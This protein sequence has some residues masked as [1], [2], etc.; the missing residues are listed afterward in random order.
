[1]EIQVPNHDITEIV[2]VRHGQTESNVTG[3]FMGWSSED[4]NAAGEEQAREL[5]SRL[6]AWSL[7]AAF[8][9]PLK[10]TTHTAQIIAGPYSIEVI[11]LEDLIEINQ[12]ELQ[13][14]RRSE[15]EKKWP[16]LCQHLRTD[17]SQ[18]VFPGGESFSQVAMRTVA[19]FTSVIAQNPG[20]RTLLVSH[21]INI[22]IIVM[23]VL[24]VPY[25]VYRR[26][27]INNAS[28]SLVQAREDSFKLITLNDTSHLAGSPSLQ[29]LPRLMSK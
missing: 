11:P 3:Y 25:N 12:G 21:E 18:A 8:A 16:V 22:K 9:S 14:T 29:M 24:G 10:R 6:A 13:G 20:K 17:P 4:I 7:E 26:F 27:E 19:A 23:H 2:L 5:S 15:T 1:M 28:L